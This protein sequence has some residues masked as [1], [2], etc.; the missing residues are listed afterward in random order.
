MNKV[1]EILTDWTYQLE[2]GYP[3]KDEDYILLQ[4]ILQES[5]DFDQSTIHR[6]VDK[7][8]G[9]QEDEVPNEVTNNDTPDIIPDNEVNIVVNELMAVFRKISNKYADY[10]R[11]INSFAPGSVG[12]MSE[13]ILAGLINKYTNANAEAVGMKN[14]LTDI[15][16]GKH[17]ISLKASLGSKVIPLSVDTKNWPIGASAESKTNWYEK[18]AAG[19]E[20]DKTEPY[21]DRSIKFLKTI[22]QMENS[23]E[24]EIYN[25]IINRLIAIAKKLSDVNFIW[26]EKEIPQSNKILKSLT[27]HVREYEYENIMKEFLNSHLYLSPKSWGLVGVDGSIIIG[28]DTGKE[29]NI[30][31]RFI[32]KTSTEENTQRIEFPIP[33]FDRIEKQKEVTDAMLN[34]LEQISQ[35]LYGN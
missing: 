27:I 22:N 34:S 5:T 15:T 25:V 4:N 17:H 12:S 21:G 30:H 10:I 3:K 28:A 33:T 19:N 23:E 9:L 20:G 16:V 13:S 35:T 2:S 7:A 6:I 14:A 31:P 26:I 8:R 18:Y 11:V 24:A 1:N 29:L 32:Q